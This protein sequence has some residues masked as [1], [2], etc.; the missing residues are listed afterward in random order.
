MG[1]SGV[2]GA[3]GGVERMVRERV[4]W[5]TG[6][7]GVDWFPMA[8]LGGMAGGN[9]SVST[10]GGRAG[11]C[12]GNSGGT[13]GL[14]RGASTLGDA[15]GFSLGVGWVWFGG[16]GRRMSRMRV[17]ASSVWYAAWPVHL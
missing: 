11:I 6:W 10:L 16:G 3:G 9:A 12:T 7:S 1:R 13:G 4:R 15:G 8:I 14:D 2:C 17:R 5:D